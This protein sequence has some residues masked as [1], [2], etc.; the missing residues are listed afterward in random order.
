MEEVVKFFTFRVLRILDWFKLTGNFFIYFQHLNARY[1][2]D[3]RFNQMTQLCHVAIV[4]SFQSVIIAVI[5]HLIFDQRNGQMSR[6]VTS[7]ICM[8][9]FLCVLKKV[10]KLMESVSF[11]PFFN[12]RIYSNLK[13]WYSNSYI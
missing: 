12:K 10:C 8:H 3:F 4:A 2:Q 9:I 6:L 11:L 13:D 1:R 5:T 7:N